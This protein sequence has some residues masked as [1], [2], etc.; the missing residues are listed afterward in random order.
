[1]DSDSDYSIV[2]S[3]VDSTT[4]VESSNQ[5]RGK[6]TGN[7]VEPALGQVPIAF[8]GFSEVESQELKSAA[9]VYS[10]VC[11]LLSRFNAQLG[12]L[13]REMSGGAAL[14]IQR[15]AR[16]HL[17]RRRCLKVRSVARATLAAR[18]APLWRCY[19]ARAMTPLGRRAF[20][21]R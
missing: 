12:I 2:S 5:A 3:D 6:F 21:R 9:A 1:M 14:V 4:Y 16:G 17:A 20:S 18:I 11:R 19:R 10:G 7:V 13:R 15:L 8:D